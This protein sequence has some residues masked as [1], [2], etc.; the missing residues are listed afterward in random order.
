MRLHDST[1]E[2]FGL[3]RDAPVTLR[4][5]P[6]APRL[7]LFIRPIRR[8][9]CSWPVASGS[10]IRQRGG[11]HVDPLRPRRLGN[12]ECIALGE[13]E[14]QMVLAAPELAARLPC[15]QDLA[16]QTLLL[17]GRLAG[18]AAS[19][20]G[21][22]IGTADLAGQLRHPGDGAGPGPPQSVHALA[23][24][25]GPRLVPVFD[26]CVTTRSVSGRRRSSGTGG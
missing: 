12:L 6:L 3:T 15:P 10:M 19:G 11:R 23:A 24:R 2:V 7:W 26:L 9:P 25:S 22:R 14:E 16:G 4:A 21:G 18:L 1:A 13:G 17:R 8:C 20:R 5:T